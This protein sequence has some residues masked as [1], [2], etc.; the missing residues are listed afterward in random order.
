MSTTAVASGVDNQNILNNYIAS[1]TSTTSASASSTS[2]ASSSLAGSYDTFLKILTTQLQNQDPTEPMDA[3]QFTQQLVM[4]SQ[5][6]QQINTNAKLDKMLSAVN[7]NGITPLMSYV[8]SYVETASSG[9]LVVQSGQALLAYTLPE[10]ATSTTIYVKNSSG[11]TIATMSGATSSGLNRLAWDGTCDD[12]TT[13]SDGTYSFSITAKDSSGS[14]M[15]LDD[16]RVIGRVTG[17]ET[18]DG[19]TV[20]KAGDLSISDTK[21]D[22]VFANIGSS[23]SSS[24]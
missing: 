19:T 13:A 8:G 4:Y 21:V 3:S 18:T 20:L 24:S 22:A 7:S 12:G 9:K 6:E 23:S 2:D 14:A 1:Q 11:K 10:D 16:V 5:V 15:T 17:I